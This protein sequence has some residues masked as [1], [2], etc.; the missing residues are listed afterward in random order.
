MYG[1]LPSWWTQAVRQSHEI[2]VEAE[3]W[4]GRYVS[5]PTDPDAATV[6]HLDLDVVA[7]RVD[8]DTTRAAWRTCSVDLVD[9]TGLI[10]PRTAEDYLT[11]YGHEIVLRRGIVYGSSRFVVPLGVFLISDVDVSEGDDGVSIQL[12]GVD[13]SAR[14][15]RNKWTQPV[16]SPAGTPVVA[17][18]EAGLVSRWGDVTLDLID[19]GDTTPLIVYEAG[20]SS[21][22]WRDAQALAESVGTVLYFDADGVVRQ[23]VPPDPTGQA[24]VASYAR[25]EASVLLTTGRRISSEDTYN[26]VVVTGE[27]SSGSVVFSGEAWD[28]N[29]ASPTYRLGPFG[30]VP[31]FVTSPLVTSTTQAQAAAVGLLQ[32]FLGRAEAVEWES[33]VDPALDGLD[34]IE[35]TNDVVGVD[36]TYV[37]EAL[38]YPLTPEEAMTGRVQSRVYSS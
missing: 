5:D 4:A 6:D 23:R 24:A 13:R 30:Q 31:Y 27:S 25:G 32:R 29:P 16:T 38:T 22:P 21:D 35:V 28:D 11:P 8:L 12:T 19:T 3:V 9:R 14:I 1:P 26:G 20:D 7:G 34:V 15:S 37:V 33:I 18:I 17:A 2:T 10:T 36:A